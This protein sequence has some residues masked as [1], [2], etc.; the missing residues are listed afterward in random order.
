[1]ISSAFL[2]P[3]L[4]TCLGAYFK[5]NFMWE[6]FEES[7]LM[8]NQTYYWNSTEGLCWGEEGLRWGYLF[9]KVRLL[10][11]LVVFARLFYNWSWKILWEMVSR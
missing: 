4:F 1:M 7:V 11:F 9:P 6:V 2:K 5:I 3:V 8:K 10:A